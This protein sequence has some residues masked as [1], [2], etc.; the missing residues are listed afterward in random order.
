MRLIETSLRELHRERSGAYLDKIRTLQRRNVKPYFLW[1][2]HF[3]EV[4][5]SE[6]GGFDIIIANPPYVD[7]EMMVKQDPQ[8]REAIG[9]RFSTTKGNWDLYIP[10]MEL[11]L[12]KLSRTGISCLITPNKWLAISYGKAFRTFAKDKIYAIADYSRFRAFENVGVFPV[13]QFA[14]QTPSTQIDISRF[15]DGHERIFSGSV[16][17]SVFAQLSTWGSVLS[18]HLPLILR[19]IANNPPLHSVCD[20]EEAFTV[21][22]AYKL[23]DIMQ[24]EKIIEDGVFKFINT[25]TIEPFYSL[26]G[27]SPTT[28]L[29]TKYLNPVI[30]QEAILRRCFQDAMSKCLHPKL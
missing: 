15:S 18:E 8:L 12:L 23:P 30:K 17:R 6:G 13:V 26:W 27:I 9:A 14:A 5:S 10:F 2:L 11:A 1:K 16:T 22:E 4:F 25:G 3:S 24:D 21:G 29:K 28:Y 7:S 19:L 20:L